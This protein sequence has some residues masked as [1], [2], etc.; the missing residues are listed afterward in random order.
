MHVC[1][2][3]TAHPWDDVRVKSKFV[4][5]FLAAGD[6]VTWIVTQN[7]DAFAKVSQQFDAVQKVWPAAVPPQQPVTSAKGL[8]DMVAEIEK[9]APAFR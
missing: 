1:V 8:Y 2:F 9:L 7:G 6:R 3:T 5:S 4:D